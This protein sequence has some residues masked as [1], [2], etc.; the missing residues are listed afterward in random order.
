MAGQERKMARL[1]RRQARERE[2]QT[3]VRRFTE[4]WNFASSRSIHEV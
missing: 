1:R 4:K 3:R 2:R